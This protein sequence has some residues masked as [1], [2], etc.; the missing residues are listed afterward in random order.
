MTLTKQDYSNIA[1]RITIGQGTIEY[2]KENETLFVYYCYTET[3]Y[4][5]NDYL[6]GTGGFVVTGIYLS[7]EADSY[8]NENEVDTENN[9]R[10]Q[11]LE[12]AIRF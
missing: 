7:A 11:E 12:Q 3:G 6:N 4:R 8:D 9:F 1:H 10:E 2:N 5:E